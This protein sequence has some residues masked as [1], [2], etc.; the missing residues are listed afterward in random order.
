M[1]WYELLLSPLSLRSFSSL[2]FWI[3]LVAFWTLVNRRVMGVPFDRVLAAREG[4]AEAASEAEALAR[5]EVRR[6]LRPSQGV[7][8][9]HVALAAFVGT[10]LTLLALAGLELAQA[11]ALMIL[12][13]LLIE[14]LRQRLARRLDAEA[15]D[16]T[17]LVDRLIWHRL[18]TQAIGGIAIFVTVLWGAWR[19]LSLSIPH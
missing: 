1:Q 18:G 10:A 8:M 3:A 17:T 9:V 11:L 16:A 6:R 5:I 12:P 14:L 15:P 7:R 19:N 2:W 13:W 4:D